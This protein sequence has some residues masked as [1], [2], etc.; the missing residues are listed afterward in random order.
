M[1]VNINTIITALLLIFIT[2]GCLWFQNIRVAERVIADNSDLPVLEEADFSQASLI[3]SPEI[4]EIS[5]R[6]KQ[7][8]GID[9]NHWSIS[10]Q[11]ELAGFTSDN[12]AQLSIAAPGTSNRYFNQSTGEISSGTDIILSEHL[13]VITSQ[14]RRAEWNGRVFYFLSV[15]VDTPGSPHSG[16]QFESEEYDDP[17]RVHRVYALDE[18]GNG[19]T[20]FETDAVDPVFVTDGVPRSLPGQPL[21]FDVH[22]SD[23]GPVVVYRDRDGIY[24]KPLVIQDSRSGEAGLRNNEQAANLTSGNGSFMFGEKKQIAI[25]EAP[26]GEYQMISRLDPNGMIHLIWTD[27]RGK[28]DLW[29]CRSNINENEICNAP[30]RISRTAFMGPV[31]LML[32]DENRVYISWIDNRFKQGVWTSRN[33]AKLMIVK[34]DDGGSRFGTPVL[35][36]P[37]RDDSDNVLY[38]VTMPAPDEGIL[39]FWGTE[40]P[41]SGAANQ[42]M[43]FGWLQG[44]ME[45][46]VLGPD[47]IPG[48]RLHDVINSKLLEYQRNLGIP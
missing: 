12:R 17:S 39:V 10:I 13:N 16:V 31:N 32:Q 1:R 28:N 33:F 2:T 36:N 14:S 5:V 42:D 9:L 8:A 40:V 38:S 27:S 7:E 20:F 37:P 29:Y 4:P 22:I 26:Y 15:A 3:Y 35:V 41:G 45:T 47:K 34:S 21:H 43:F 6:L 48:T 44:N 30:R 24:L 18:N 11:H 23:N 25:S 19:V 46:M